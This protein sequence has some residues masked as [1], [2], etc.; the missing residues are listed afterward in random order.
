M[1][2]NAV[3]VLRMD[4]Q[5]KVFGENRHFF[6][7]TTLRELVENECYYLSREWKHFVQL[8]INSVALKAAICV[9]INF[10]R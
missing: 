6:G 2:V 4:I 9:Q 10:H 1:N 5:R 3:V 7:G 8:R